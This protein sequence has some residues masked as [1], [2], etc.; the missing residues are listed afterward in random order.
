MALATS[1]FLA[2]CG[3]PKVERTAPEGS[4]PPNGQQSNVQKGMRPMLRTD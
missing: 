3:G 2:G 1:L 4:A